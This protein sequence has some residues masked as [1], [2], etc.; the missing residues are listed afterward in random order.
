[1]KESGITIMLRERIELKGQS[2]SKVSRDTG[3]SRNTI[4]KYLREGEQEHGLK[5]CK[6]PSKLDPYKTQIDLVNIT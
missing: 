4:R 3:I 6:R 2:I 1:M 5:G